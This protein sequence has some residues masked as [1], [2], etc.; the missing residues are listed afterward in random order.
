M[1]GLK[2][3]KLR[4][5]TPDTVRQAGEALIAGMKDG[6]IRDRSGKPY[7]PSTIRSY[8]A[9]L[10]RHVYPELGARKLSDVLYPDLQD[11]VDGM[12][13]KGLDGSTI[14][15]T[16]NPVRVIYRRARY[17]IPVNPTTGLEMIARGEKPRRVVSADVAAKMIE[18]VP[19]EERALRGTAFYAGLRSGELQALRVEDV[20][21][22]EQGRWGLIHVRQSWD[23]QEGAQ[24]PKSA[25]GARTVPIPEPL[26]ALLDE[27]LL[28][29]GRTS[30]LIFGR[31]ESTPFSYSGSRA[32][33]ERAYK[34]VGLEPSDLQLHECRHSY[35][36]FLEAADIRESR[37][38][39]YMGHANHSVQ[40]RYSHQ[41][42]AQYLDD[43]ND[44]SEY[45]SR[46]DTPSRIEQV[47]DN[48]ATV[49]DTA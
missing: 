39:R 38:D 10:E 33:A 36:T 46:A 14:R 17:S 23:K 26:Y 28:R 27:H 47:R 15:N 37:V 22:Y 34:G 19:L 45:L 20:E 18:S 13:A 12:A 30:G 3:G 21:R 8:D 43:A 6:S 25:A 41:L 1:Q 9:S 4:A 29:T 42:E 5:P 49:R 2:Q 44:L 35:K 32:R 16:I 40:G 24:G 31:S 48:C 7:K 11:F